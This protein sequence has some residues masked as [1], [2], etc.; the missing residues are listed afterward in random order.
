MR[1]DVM[2]NQ[3][4]RSKYNPTAGDSN[5]AV[6]RAL[7]DPSSPRTVRIE[8]DPVGQGCFDQIWR[9]SAQFTDM[10]A[11]IKLQGFGGEQFHLFNQPGINSPFGIGMNIVQ[12]AHMNHSTTPGWEP[13]PYAYG[14]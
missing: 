6:T 14:E 8:D 13:C 9:F 7:V 3:H 10:H 5:L 11:P 2:N 12:P 4:R 1:F